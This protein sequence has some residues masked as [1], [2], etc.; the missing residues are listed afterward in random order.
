MKGKFK[1]GLWMLLILALTSCQRD[2]LITDW[3]GFTSYQF[4]LKGKEARLVIPDQALPGKPWL[5]HARFPDYHSEIDSMLAAE[6]F[7]IA[8]INTDNQYGS[9][10]AMA[11]W[12]Q[13]YTHL[14]ETYELHKKVALSGHSRGGLFI[15]NWAARNPEKVAAIYAEAPVCDFKSWPAGFGASE[16]SPADWERLKKAY[17]FS[18]DEE[19]TAY[20]GNPLDKLEALAIARIPLLHTVGLNDK[21]VPPDENTFPLV[22]KYIRLGGSAIVLPCTEGVHTLEGHHFP[23]DEPRKVVDFFIQ[24]STNKSPLD[25]PGDD[26]GSLLERPGLSMDEGWLILFGDGDVKQWRSDQGNSF[27]E[28]GWTVQGDVLILN[29]PSEGRAV[30]AGN[31]LTR[32]SYSNFELHFEW[33]ILTPGGNSG[34]KYFVPGDADSYDTYGPGPEYQLLDDANHPW[35][36]EGKM[37]PNDYHTLGACYELYEADPGKK[38]APLG[39]WNSSRIVSQNGLVEHWL[40]GQKILEYDRFSEDFAHRVH[41]SK[42]KE[43]PKFGQLEK[44]HILLQDHPGEVHFRN[45]KIRSSPH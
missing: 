42:F 11:T 9:P 39:E 25:A 34:V 38:P 5:W 33:K 21:I 23:I 4:T 12:D 30:K 31:L 20:E 36:L 17:G 15:Y 19:A 45:I 24:H 44:G 7:H 14:T 10:A 41:Q 35:M 26:S 29:A 16:G 1:T 32:N 22:E 18:S 43:F 13:F 2:L 28:A 27:P 8:Y 40:N 37:Q 6:G 3:K